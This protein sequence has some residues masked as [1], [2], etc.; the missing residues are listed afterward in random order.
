M[1]KPQNEADLYK[2]CP[3]CAHELSLQVIEDQD[4]KK[5]DKCGFIFWNNPKPAA[6][7]LIYKDN[8]VLMLQRAQEPLKGY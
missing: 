7:A 5:C 1:E 6:S 4:V 2:F 3:Q 8:T